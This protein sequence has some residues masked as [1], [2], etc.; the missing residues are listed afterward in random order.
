MVDVDHQ[1][2]V[3]RR[4]GQLGV[5]WVARIGLMLVTPAVAGVALEHPQH[6]GLDVGGQDRPLGA[7]PP[8]QADAVVAGAGADVGHGR[9]PG[10][11][12]GVEHR[13]GLLFLDARLTKQP[14]DPLP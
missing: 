7:D 1:D 6:L 4:L 10:D 11:L 13:L 8:G 5:G 9:A 14:V 12:E 2:Q 3:D